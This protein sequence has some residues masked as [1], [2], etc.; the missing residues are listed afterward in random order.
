M[1]DYFFNHLMIN[2]KAAWIGPDVEWHQESFNINT[3]APGYSPE[4]DWDK[5]VQFFIPLD[6]QTKE[7]GC[8]K[9]IPK[10]HT[11]GLLQYEDIIN[12]NLVHKRRVK[13]EDMNFAFN[14]FGIKDI[15]LNAGDMLIFNHLLVHGSGTNLSPD[16]RKAVVLQAQ[17]KLLK[18][19]NE[20]FEKETLFRSNFVKNE[21]EKKLNLTNAKKMYRD[22]NK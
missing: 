6:N 19:D 22:F 2:N 21:L 12:A 3:Y 4:K 8:L 1:G 13:Y 10:S 7:N 18:K 5:F 14:K 11:L 9:I 16:D 20:I 17:K 15:I